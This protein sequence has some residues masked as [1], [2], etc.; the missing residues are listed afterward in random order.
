MI[1]VLTG[2]CA[3]THHGLTG[4]QS[5]ELLGLLLQVPKRGSLAAIFPFSFSPK[6]RGLCPVC[7]AM[8]V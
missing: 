3:L 7:A 2:V 5:L 6:Q 4:R 1:W 8:Y